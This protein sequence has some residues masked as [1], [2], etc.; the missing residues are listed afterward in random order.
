MYNKIPIMKKSFRT[1]SFGCRVNEAERLEINK[2]LFKRGL[3]WSDNM[4]DIFIINTCS[5]TEKA[6]REAR[7]F[8]YQTK[9]KYPYTKI[10]ATGCSATYWLKNNLYKNLPIDFMIGNN[11]KEFLADYLEKWINKSK[12]PTKSNLFESSGKFINSGR[13]L[14]KIQDGC[15]RFCSYCIVPYLRGKPK[16]HSIEYLVSSIQNEKR[17]IN[18]LILTAINTQSFGYDTG[19]SFIN[20]LKTIIDKTCVPRISCGSIHP[21]S[22]DNKFIEFYKKYQNHHRLVDFFHIPIQSGSNKILNMMKRGYSREEIGEKLQLIY[23][24]NPMALIATDIIVGFLDESDCDFQETYNFLKNSPISKFHVFRY[25]K[26]QNTAAYYL[27]KRLKEPA[28]PI[29]TKRSKALIELGKDKYQRFLENHIGKSF[30]ALFLKKGYNGFQEGLLENQ[31]T[32]YIKTKSDLNGEIKNV[33]ITGY[34]NNRLFG[35]IS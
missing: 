35:K 3:I 8:I 19:E 1:F 17:Q 28:D 21:W 2:E 13:L 33:K 12:T 7:Q 5:V 14:L 23:E 4:P 32:A 15:N 29:K 26:R 24:L 27:A 22:I 20:L 18:E 10:V 9:R 11:Q 6:E 16:S 25:S 30:T 34:K 31:V